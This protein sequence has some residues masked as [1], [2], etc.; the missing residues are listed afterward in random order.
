MSHP[1]DSPLSRQDSRLNLTD[2]YVFRGGTGTVF[3]MNVNTS[4][5]GNHRRTGF[6]PS[7]RYEFK[8][9][10]NGSAREELAYRVAFAEVDPDGTQALEMHRFTGPQA[11]DDT[12]GGALLADGRTGTVVHGEAGLRLWAGMA[13]D[14]FYLDL[15]LL[16]RV[17]TAVRNGADIDLSGWRADAAVN[18]FAGA[19]VHAI[20][21]EIHDDDAWLPSDGEIGVWSTIK[22]ATDAGACWQVNRAGFPMMWPLFRADDG[23]YAGDTNTTHPVDDLANDGK[24]VADLVAG[25]VAARGTCDDPAG[26]GAA[27]ARRLLPDVLPYRT[28]TRAGFDFSRHNGRALGDNA[29]EVMFSLVTNSAVAT[30]LTAAGT[31][32]TRGARFPYVVPAA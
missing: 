30:G 29:P 27:L 21:L 24:H 15:G 12:A 5:A 3:V 22:L 18:T 26:Y 8:I 13:V 1:L 14:P 25:L 6:H 31:A 32:H 9:H 16:G 23:R 20:V 4:L 11:R 10:V 7:A 2:Q 19:T 17:S 28:G